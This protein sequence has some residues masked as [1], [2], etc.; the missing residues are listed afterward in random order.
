[1]PAPI[2]QIKR[3][4]A[5]VAGTVPALR[6]GEPAISLNNF[7]FFVGIDSSVANNKFF[8]SHRYW[9][10]E[11]GTISLKLKLVDKNGTN[12]IHIKSPN[13][14]S[15]IG[16]YTLPDTST[17]QSG[18]FLKVAS[19]G[20]LS[21]D[22]VGGTNGTFTNTSF[23]GI[24]TISGSLNNTANTTNSG[25]T[26]FTNTTDNT[27]GNSNTGAVQIDGGVGIDKNLTVGA[28][29]YVGGYSEFVGVGTF[30][31]GAVIDAVQI[32]ITSPG[33]IDTSTGSLTLDSASGQTTIDDNLFVTGI[34]TIT[35]SF[36]ANGNVTLGDAAGD[37]ITFKGTTTFEQAITG[38]ATTSNTVSVTDTDSVSGNIVFA[39]AGI[40]ATLYND[41]DL[42]YDSNTNI[43]S[44]PI[45]SATTE[46]RTGS[47]KAEDGTTS[48]TISNTT[49]AVTSANDFTVSGNLYVNG[50]TTQVNTD[51]LTVEDRII[52]LGRIHSGQPTS[53]TW[54]LAVL[55]NYGDGVDKKS[56]VV[57]EASGVTK[58]FQFTSDISTGVDGG[59]TDTNLPTLTV[60]NFA[61]IEVSELWINNACTGGAQQVIGCVGSEL[62]LQNITVDAGAF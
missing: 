44:V 8:G 34:A 2:L 36:F 1:M 28:N 20:T 41:T 45:L 17:I 53:T 62:Q 42:T 10:R 60:V 24:T 49:G 23:V 11:D 54:D 52:E 33:E 7:D 59:P 27:L 6:P 35:G 4:N 31:T 32:G 22:A 14:V 19:D 39:T 12:G 26:S 48:L 18:Y 21:W 46:V 43:L 40:G 50:S 38:T 16:T 29:L 30:A 51:T 61:P 37:I 55:F 13:T 57:W 56:G 25:I 15:G 3:G 5:G 9:G 47:V 58:R